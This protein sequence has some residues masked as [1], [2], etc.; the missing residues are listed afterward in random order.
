MAFPLPEHVS[1]IAIVGSGTIGASWTSWFLARS[2]SVRLT[3]PDAGREG[4]VRDYIKAAWPA[5]VRIGAA[6]EPDPTAALARLSFHAEVE[7]AV[8]RADFVQ[9]NAF[10][11]LDL[12]QALLARIDAVLPPDRVI[13]TSTSGFGASA[14]QRDMAHPERL[15]IGH[16][17]NPPHLIP[18]VEVVGGDRTE[19]AAIA[20]GLSFYRAVGKRP[21]RIRKEVPGHLANRLQVALWREAVH[22]VAEGVASVEDVDAAIAYGPGLRWALMGPHLTFHLGGRQ[23]GM[24]HFVDHLG[25]PITGWWA[26]LGR[27]EL[28]PKI[29]EMLVAGVTEEVGE[30]SFEALVSERD[31]KL[32]DLLDVLG[33]A[34]DEPGQA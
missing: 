32:L 7:A 9:E 23:G 31:R 1:T 29:K 21:I 28:T 3:N 5:L 19:E 30:C 2:R 33:L 25:P 17:F 34:R 15:I 27:P 10:E 24:R 6:Q 18:L 20:W 26:D 13:A 12:K 8:E 11:R 16:P 22:L 14:L 4:F